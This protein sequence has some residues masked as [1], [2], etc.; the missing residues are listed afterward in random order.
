LR[1]VEGYLPDV[2]RYSVRFGKPVVLPAKTQ[3]YVNRIADGWELALRNS[4]GEPHLTG[5]VSAL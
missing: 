4:K 2:V 3:L 1:T 5:T